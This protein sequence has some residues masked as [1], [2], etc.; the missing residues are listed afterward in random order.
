MGETWKIL[1]CCTL[2]EWGKRVE[3]EVCSGLL[4]SG[5]NGLFQW[6]HVMDQV[7]WR[8]ACGACGGEAMKLPSPQLE[9]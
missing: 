1:V 8:G 2:R 6:F 9:D 3:T 7:V 4:L 5:C